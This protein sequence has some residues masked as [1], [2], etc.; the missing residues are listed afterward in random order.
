MGP[1]YVHIY[2]KLKTS[3]L[4]AACPWFTSLPYLAI[5]LWPNLATISQ[6]LLILLFLLSP[7]SSP[8]VPTVRGKY[9]S[10]LQGKRQNRCTVPLIQLLITTLSQHSDALSW[11]VLIF[12]DD[13]SRV[14][15][16][17]ETRVELE[18]QMFPFAHPSRMT[19]SFRRLLPLLLP[20]RVT[21]SLKAIVD[22]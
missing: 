18:W 3:P 10:T 8:L 16:L 21:A 22:V 2:S 1:P 17:L 5:E 20:Y 6:N 11:N 13:A 4:T 12:S 7:L 15:F 19:C 9:C 14:F